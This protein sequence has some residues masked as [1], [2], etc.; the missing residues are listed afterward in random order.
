MKS[1]KTIYLFVTLVVAIPLAVFGIASLYEKYFQRLPILGP[2]QHQVSDFSFQDHLGE[3]ITRG[4]WKGKIVLAGY[5]F[6]SCSSVCP[7]M[8]AQVKRVQALEDKNVLINFFTVDPKRD[9]VE[10]LERYADRNGINSNWLLLTGD[11]I[12][13]YRFARKDLMIEATD[14]DGGPGDFIHSDNLVL[15]D[16][17]QRIR[18]YYKGTDDGEVGRLI[19]DINKLKI[20]FKL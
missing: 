10:K 3:T 14:G 20:E 19:H 13:L 9:S 6:T 5:F 15:I 4:N 16:P 12:S 11:K 18:G 1:G 8:V 17:Q 2:E 7:K